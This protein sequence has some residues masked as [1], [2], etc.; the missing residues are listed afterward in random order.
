MPMN[1]VHRKLCSSE[2]WAR[3]TRELILPWA[4]E[5][6][7]LGEDVLEIGPG[8]GANLRVLVERVPRLTGAEIDAD[9]VRLLR[10]Q[11]GDRVRILHADGAELPL[12][13]GSFDSVLSFTMLHH[14][15]TATQQ[16]GIFAEAFRVLRPGGTFAG[17]DSL[18]S[19]GFRVLHLWDT[20][21]TLDPAVLPARLEKTGFTDVRVDRHPRSN[22][23]RFRARKP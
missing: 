23:I 14:V 20:R 19:F 13:D 6:V 10:E 17:N 12:P 1:R 11:W 7:D 4:L 2:K 15:P 8:Y 21:T 18:S 5:G 3:T 16:D 22:G 9:T